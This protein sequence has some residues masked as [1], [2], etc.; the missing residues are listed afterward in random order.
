MTDGALRSGRDDVL[1]GGRVV[2]GEDD[3]HVRLDALDGE[4]LAVEQQLVAA[5]LRAPQQLATRVHRR[6]RG[7]LRAL[8]PCEL[9]LGLRAAAI[10]EELL[11]HVELDPVGTEPVGEPDR[12]VVRHGRALEPEARDGP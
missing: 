12:E 2:R 10:V 1:V 8:H 4:L 3:V 6:L 7:P 9:R 11:V 5:S